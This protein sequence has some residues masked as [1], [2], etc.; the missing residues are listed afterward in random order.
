MKLAQYCCKIFN[1]F[2][3]RMAHF[4]AILLFLITPFGSTLK[5]QHYFH[6]S[7][8]P[9]YLVPHRNYM[10]NMASPTFGGHVAVE[11]K[12]SGNTHIDSLAGDFNWGFKLYYSHLGNPGLSGDVWALNP[13]FRIRLGSDRYGQTFLRLGTGLG[14]FTRIFDPEKNPT[15]RAIS[16]RLNGAM[17]FHLM[18]Y[19]PVHEA[20][21]IHYG[22]GISHFSNGNYSRP[23][24]GINMPELTVGLSYR[25]KNCK[26]ASVSY[27]PVLARNYWELRGGWGSKQARVSDPTRLQ[28]YTGSF[29]Y[30]WAQSAIRNLR[31][32]LDLNYDAMNAYVPF[33]PSTIEEA[34]LHDKLELGLRSGMEYRYNAVGVQLE[35]GAY[36]YQPAL[37]TKYPVY[38]AVGM[39]Y[40]YK[41]FAIGPRLKTHLGVADFI[42]IGLQ[43]RVFSKSNKS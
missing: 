24:L 28:V 19:Q 23:N 21:S 29:T 17:H 6:A 25:C 10:L 8:T 9:G 27:E 32:G 40:H 31:F 15:N 30:G 11:F 33:Y 26:P 1:I 5:G 37:I 7:L 34:A 39:Q 14:Y 4:V 42:D 41:K 22:V 13:Y 12:G 36:L 38:I 43:Y 18:R 16:N 2:A 35:L 20:Y 3:N